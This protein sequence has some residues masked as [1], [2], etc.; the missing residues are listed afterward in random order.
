MAC[1]LVVVVD[2]FSGAEVLPVSWR[3]MEAA[4]VVVVRPPIRASWWGNT[5]D[6]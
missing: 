1:G 4:A 6:A 2:S 3:E 5:A